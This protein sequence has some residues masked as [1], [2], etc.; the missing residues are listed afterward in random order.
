MLHFAINKSQNCFNGW[1]QYVTLQHHH[2]DKSS[3][4]RLKTHDYV[5]Y[6]KSCKTLI[7]EILKWEKGRE[8]D[9][10]L[11]E[12]GIWWELLIS[13]LVISV[14]FKRN[15]SRWSVYLE[16]SD[17][18]DCLSITNS[19]L[20]LAVDKSEATLPNTVVTSHPKLWLWALEMQLI[21][22]DAGCKYKKTLHP[23][24]IKTYIIFI[25]TTYWNDNIWDIMGL[26]YY[27]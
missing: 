11:K 20:D 4:Q 13:L 18:E 12:Y 8:Y 17:G 5:K 10:E 6:T 3:F 27:Y 7:L 25:L 22:T 26:T 14:F 21:Q 1:H 24:E 23:K 16:C 2:S 19:A 15:S 9:S